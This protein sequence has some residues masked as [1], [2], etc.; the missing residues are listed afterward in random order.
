MES[1]LFRVLDLLG[2]WGLFASL[3]FSV[4]F[5]AFNDIH[6]QENRGWWIAQL[7]HNSFARRYRTLVARV[8]GA[9]DVRFGPEQPGASFLHHF[10]YASG[11]ACMKLALFLAL[12]AMPLVL[13]FT[14]HGSRIGPFTV[15]DDTVAIG[16]RYLLLFVIAIAG[17]AAHLISRIGRFWLR[18]VARVA[19]GAVLFV[20]LARLF[21]LIA[22][23]PS[24]PE[25]ALIGTVVGFVVLSI[26]RI[27]NLFLLLPLLLYHFLV[28]VQ[29]AAHA[30]FL[31]ARRR[32]LA[33]VG[34]AAYALFTAAAFLVSSAVFK[35]PVK[36]L[37]Q[38][39][40]EI[41]GDWGVSLGAGTPEARREMAMLI[42]FMTDN[43]L[44]FFV[45][46]PVVLG[47]SYWVALSASR[48]LLAWGLQGSMLVPAALDLLVAVV[49][50][51]VQ[52]LLVVG[53][54]QAFGL[55]TGQ[56]GR[57]GRDVFSGLLA[58]PAAYTWLTAPILLLMLPV[59]LHLA[60]ACFSLFGLILRPTGMA[61]ARALQSREGAQ[62]R[63]AGLWLTAA[64]TASVCLPAYAMA[65]FLVAV[66]LVLQFLIEATFFR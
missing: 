4:A 39:L 51:L 50:V 47:L 43:S 57:L 25:L 7:R 35:L 64:A 54:T 40:A 1:L 16:H 52:V 37:A 30:L 61:V 6:R 15:F 62:G 49:L 33:A 38:G 11:V 32:G 20:V 17:V 36:D 31:W 42:A 58:E 46:L 56:A 28:P 5:Y 13:V 34:F 8:L 48:S 24:A 23:R 65:Q 26:R 3:V 2:G 9:L 60:V 29:A 66:P 41:E 45:I 21:P 22:R 59:T 44:I 53:V 14:G 10:T 55:V 63:F 18:L 27:E 19:V 12:L